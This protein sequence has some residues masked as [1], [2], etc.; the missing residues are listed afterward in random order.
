MQT[1]VMNMILPTTSFQ[2][3]IDKTLW[4]DQVTQ[5][6]KSKITETIEAC[7]VRL[8]AK[9]SDNRK[10]QNYRIYIFQLLKKMHPDLGISGVAIEIVNS[11]VIEML[12]RI[13][14]ES[15]NLLAKVHHNPLTICELE[16]AVTMCLWGEVCKIW[17]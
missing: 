3:C 10:I 14:I 5:G 1:F 2:R 15:A 8:T 4:F 12:E 7:D 17:K 13:A 16:Y 6:S 11:F 9:R